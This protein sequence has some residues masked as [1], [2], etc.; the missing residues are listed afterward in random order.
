MGKDRSARLTVVVLFTVLLTWSGLARAQT[1]P[2]AVPSVQQIEPEPPQSLLTPSPPTPSGDMI[3][4]RVIPGFDEWMKAQTPFIR[5]S[6]LRLHLRS[7]YL[8]RLN[9]DDTRNEAWA[10][11][12]W[13][14]FKSGWLLDTFAVGLTSY[15][16]QPLYAPEDAPGTTLLKPP[17]DAIV[18]LGQL[19]GQLRYQEYVLLTG[20][21][22]LIDEGYVNL[23]DNR[24]IPN[25]FEGVTA[26]GR[27]GWLG[28][29]FGYITAMKPRNE[30]KFKNMAKIAGVQDK[31]R[32]LGLSRLSAEPIQDLKLYAANY[33]VPDVFSTTFGQAEYDHKLGDE[34][35]FKVGVQYTDQ[36]AV[37]SEFLGDFHTWNVGTFGGVRW[38]G[39]SAGTAFS[40]TG[41]D[42]AIRTPYGTFPGYLSFQERDF[43]R[44]RETAW[45]VGMKYDFGSGTLLPFRIPGLSALVRYAHG[46]DAR[47]PGK[48]AELPNVKET[49]F[50]VTWN[51]PWV[52]GLQ[53]RF[54]NAYVDDGGSRTVQAFRI[55]INYEFPLF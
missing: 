47:D 8:D 23:Q 7:F 35:S 1:P 41:D 51:L 50:D 39:L 29:D 27:L 36:R 17:Q 31:T 10:F 19:Y 44:A 30:D 14:D 21:R 46:S 26:K 54:R 15:T 49:D 53:I 33:Y 24:M 22:Q 40:I 16:S 5:D 38:R 3:L 37:G 12:G 2:P 18:V 28:Y 6:S 42:A 32:G 13:L 55:I 52:Q 25:T 48:S 9:S 34:L 45:G 20:Y 11:G 43:N 4:R